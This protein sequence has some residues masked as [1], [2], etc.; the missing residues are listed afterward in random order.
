MR[1]ISC[2]ILSALV[3]LWFA[4]SRTLASSPSIP[5][6]AKATTTFTNSTPVPIPIG[7]ATISSQIVVSGV[8]PYLWDVDA[9]TFITHSWCGDLDITLTSPAGTI[10]TLTTDNGGANA[11]VFNGT[12][13]DDQAN[14]GG[15]VPYTNN[16]G[17]VTDRTYA[18]GVVAPSLVPE[19][20]F[21]AFIG[22]NP[23]GVWTL[24]ICDDF[25]AIAGGNLA[26]WSLLTT[27]LPAAPA[28]SPP[29]VLHNNTSVA[30]P[31]NGHVTSQINATTFTGSIH[32]VRVLTI[33]THTSCGDLDITLESPR[34]TVVTLTTDNGGGFDNI[35]QG[36]LW[37][38]GANP[39]GP[40]PYDHND[41]LVTDYD[42]VANWSISFLVPEEALAAFI[43]EDPFG[44]WILTISDDWTL[45]TGTLNSWTLEITT[46]GYADTDGDG[47]GNPCDP[48]PT[49]PGNDAFGHIVSDSNTP[50][51]P[52]FQF[53][54]ISATGT[55]VPFGD[56][57][58]HGPLPLGFA[59]NY[60][61]FDYTDCWLSS[62]GWL[63]VGA[64]DPGPSD[65]GNDCPLPSTFSTN[66]IIAGIWDDLDNDGIGVA[67]PGRGYYQSFPAGSCP[68]GGYPGACFIAQWQGMY[69]FPAGAASTPLTF[70][71]MLFD[72]GDILLQ[73]LDAGPELGS[74]STTGIENTA[75]DDAITYACDTAASLSD[76]LAVVYFTDLLDNDRI[77]ELYDNCPTVPNALQTDTDGD[78]VGDV[79][80]GCPNDPLKTAAGL[81]GCGES[82]SLD[83]D[84]DGVPD[85]V[86]SCPA[87]SNPLQE[88]NDHDGVGDACQGPPGGGACGAC[89]AGGPLVLPLTILGL[90]AFRGRWRR[91]ST[92]SVLLLLLAIAPQARAEAPVLSGCA[93]T[94]TTF[95]NTTPVAF[96]APTALV[97]SQITVSGVDPYLW[98]L[99][100]QTFITHTWANDL[101][102]TLTSP[103]GTVVTL[104]TDNGS[105][106][107]NV[108]N[109]TMWDDQA[110][111][112][113][114]VPYATNDGLVT[115]HAYAHN[116]VATHLVPEEPFAAFIG[117]DPNGTWT[118]TISDDVPGVDGGDLAR[119][120]LF[121]TTL[122]AAPI[123]QPE[124][125]FNNATTTPIADNAVT[126]S[127]VVVSNVV[128]RIC[129][130]RVGT[131][132]AAHAWCP[133]LD[134]TLTSP[135]GTV[136]TLTTDNGL[137][138]SFNGTTWDDDANPLGQV[139][140]SSNNN[141]VTDHNYVNNVT[142][143]LVTPE[144]AL[145]AFIG[146]E[147]N[148]NWTLTISDDTIGNTG[149]LSIWAVMITACSYP[150]G[151]GDGVGDPCDN[152]QAVAN[153][154]QADTDGD[155]RGDV[156]DNCPLVANANQADTD[157][158]NV[159]DACDGCPNDRFKIAPG[160][161]GCGVS[162]NFDGDGDAIPDC[163]DN[164]PNVAN[165]AQIDSNGNGVGDA[166]EP[167][168]AGQP[169]GAC[170]A[171]G[172]IVLPLTALG[173]MTFRFAARRRSRR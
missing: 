116:V 56:E 138:D 40:L 66:N 68:Y 110:N 106:F 35:F 154:N 67:T 72:D 70:E 100:V 21:G 42:Y 71:I 29:H 111:P 130:V 128:G 113:G 55:T 103:A 98:D 85:C 115:D 6:C 36:T 53:I 75:E 18:D 163:V 17:L 158:D 51:G 2:L 1:V 31:D 10:V 79:C 146:E 127:V 19:E 102:I 161:C 105:S 164:C 74:G 129:K 88:D 170:G 28:P 43:G 165:T 145:G 152:C 83:T 26:S 86:D 118:L 120:S 104:T 25:P 95:T 7:T 37:D 32:K 92:L 143:M 101:D 121:V 141:M 60:Y 167:P 11:D 15:Q 90:V 125:L 47:I 112:G 150:D 144:E 16:S 81:C 89:G 62:N 169:C 99:D 33:I 78:G 94:T 12:L 61:G 84:G 87:V 23:N 57:T 132:F 49:I 69:H 91:F 4:E 131:S 159:G 153:V 172:P 14:P 39:G 107:D 149:T 166:C 73:I 135:A 114:Q 137:A 122:P 52:P 80:D 109:G 77:P 155:R 108:F 3:F 63:H 64:D 58:K 46:S 148:G 96:Q 65:P 27:T 160:L 97:T 126:Q 38:D 124:L 142:A 173:L 140:Y 139:P 157:G 147:P 76:N 22:E 168:P 123:T 171:G 44:P 8:D 5:G 156:C 34:G 41:G 117:E 59:F 24:T 50:G 136:V 162:D 30:I 119:W 9:Q 134:M 45:N 133:D 93:G 48:F 54:D 13:W 20:H 82:D 151:D